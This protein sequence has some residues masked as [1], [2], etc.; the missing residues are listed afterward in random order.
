MWCQVS[1]ELF[2][3]GD[4]TRFKSGKSCRER[5]FNHVD[6]AL[7]KQWT[8]AEELIMMQE[9]NENGKKWA[10]VVPLLNHSK[11]EHMVKNRFYSLLKKKQNGKK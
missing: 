2:L 5:W 8:T 6:P 4:M 1:K 9:I 7:N 10:R 3:R 11:S